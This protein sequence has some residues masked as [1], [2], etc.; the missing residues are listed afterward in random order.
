MKVAASLSWMMLLVP[1]ALAC[2]ALAPTKP[3]RVLAICGDVR[4][5]SGDQLAEFQLRLLRKDQT[6]VAEVKTDSV[7]NFQF[8]SVPEG[9]YYLAATNGWALGWPIQVTSS[10]VVSTCRSPLHVQPA[11]QCG[12][13][14][15]KK[16]YHSK[17]SRRPTEW[18]Q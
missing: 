3:V 7:G 6:L 10:K 13:S 15:S 9:D 4:A 12:G 1:M 14:V 11:L 17:F 8:A 2:E 16:G 18:S 5:P